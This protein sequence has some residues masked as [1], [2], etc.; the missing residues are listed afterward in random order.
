ML[1]IAIES[2]PH[3][4]GS[5]WWLMTGVE[6]WAGVLLPSTLRCF[7]YVVIFYAT[8]HACEPFKIVLLYLY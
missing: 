8:T 4:S 1:D 2:A 7:W 6:L 5:T 3:F